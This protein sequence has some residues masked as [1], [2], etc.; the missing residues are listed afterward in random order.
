MDLTGKAKELADVMKIAYE[1]GLTTGAGGNAS[2]RVEGGILI[3]PSGMFKGRL[4]AEDMVLIDDRGNVLRGGRPSSEWRMHVRIYRVRDD[5]GSILHC[6]HPLLTGI[7]NITPLV[8]GKWA[9]APLSEDDWTEE[10]R[11][12]LRSV[13]IV[14]WVPYGTDDLALVVSEAMRD[15]NAVIIKRHGAVVASSDLWGALSAM[16]SLVE[17]FE[18]YWMRALWSGTRR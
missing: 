11:L 12:L 13:K 8:G 2:V 1:R 16:D 17:V 14:P 9:Y 6:H 15:S 10:A 18:I 4:R 5:V 3:T 7:A